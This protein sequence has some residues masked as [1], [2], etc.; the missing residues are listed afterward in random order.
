MEKEGPKDNKDQFVEVAVV[1][2]SGAFPETGADRVPANQKVRQQLKAAALAL[3][4]ADTAN[5]VAKVDG[6]EI[7]PETSYTDNGLK[8]KVHID[9]GPREGGGGD[10]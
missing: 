4:L 6:H 3:G 5:W 8:G 9:W 1:T 7:N 2:T 10:A